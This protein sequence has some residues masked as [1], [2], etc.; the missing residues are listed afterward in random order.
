[1]LED[2]NTFPPRTYAVMVHKLYLDRVKDYL[3]SDPSAEEQKKQWR[4]VCCKS[5]TVSEGHLV[6]DKSSE[7]EHEHSKSRAPKILD[8]PSQK[9]VSRSRK[10]YSLLLV[11]EA[12]RTIDTMSP[13]ARKNISWVGQIEYHYSCCHQC[14][15]DDIRAN[16]ESEESSE[17]FKRPRLQDVT[18]NIGKKLFQT[19][20]VNGFNMNEE[21]SADLLRVDVYPREYSEEICLNIQRAAAAAVSS[22]TN[23]RANG[24]QQTTT[25]IHPYES[26]IPMTMSRSRCTHR[27]TVIQITSAGGTVNYY[28]GCHSRAYG[29]NEDRAIMDSKLNHEASD[30]LPVQ[31]T[32]SKTGQDLQ[33]NTSKEDSSKKMVA[34]QAEVVDSIPVSR[35]YYKL[36]EVWENYLQPSEKD[37][38][39][40]VIDK[41]QQD[42]VA[43]ASALDLG[44]SPGGWTQCLVKS[45][46]MPRV[47]AVDA[48]ALARRVAT[49]PGV[50][51]LH[52]R[53][54]EVDLAP[55][56]PYNVAVCDASIIWSRLLE[57]IIGKVIGAETN[58]VA[59]AKWCL[60]SLWV[61]T[62]K[63]PFKTPGSIQNQLNGMDKE[64][65]ILLASMAAKL[66]PD[67]EGDR[68][69]LRYRVVHLM[70]NSDSERTLLAV[71]EKEN[72]N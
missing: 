68:V 52:G 67:N 40:K 50:T 41:Q 69:S 25:K 72:S 14:K 7:D 59:A 1:M 34:T 11:Q 64:F 36:S 44:A 62:L 13:M 2:C 21:T 26:P 55:H 32:D 27:M 16:I 3:T 49:L 4:T 48:A 23:G 57:L 43:G 31:P 10:G 58:S 15:S 70:A 33:K 46:G 5:S 24:T 53:M 63:L 18:T 12:K 22:S 35:A 17:N 38:L 29:S 61:I 9:G 60:P 56:G 37:L 30:D 20:L 71:F 6:V 19:L 66:Y 51:H 42:S 54:E 8:T 28:W 65:P 47:V 45:M 39:V